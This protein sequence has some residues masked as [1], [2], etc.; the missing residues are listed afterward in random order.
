MGFQGGA[1]GKEPANAGD[2]RDMG[3][4]PG[5]GRCPGGGHGNPLQCSYL[6]NPM[7]RG[8]WQPTVYR[9]TKS[10]TDLKRLCTH[11]FPHLHPFCSAPSSSF[12]LPILKQD[13]FVTLESVNHAQAPSSSF[14][15]R[16]T[17]WLCPAGL[18]FRM[19]PGCYFPYFITPV[20]VT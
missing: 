10:G 20:N 4:I 18:L 12:R 7:D 15:S 13:V 6:E 3:L 1:S 14:S 16:S 9:V 11:T 19:P 2:I 8:A 17:A 5:S